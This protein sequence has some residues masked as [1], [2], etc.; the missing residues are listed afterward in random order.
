MEEERFRERLTELL[1]IL[2]REIQGALAVGKLGDPEVQRDLLGLLYREINDLYEE[3]TGWSM[4]GWY[5]KSL[6][7]PEEREL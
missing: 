4:L 5:M 7:R 6:L 2:E 1:D 3:A